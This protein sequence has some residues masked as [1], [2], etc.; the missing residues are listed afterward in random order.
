MEYLSNG[1]NT[2]HVDGHVSVKDVS[3][4]FR[5]VTRVLVTSWGYSTFLAHTYIRLLI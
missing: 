2:S 5:D 3:E 1:G 4:M